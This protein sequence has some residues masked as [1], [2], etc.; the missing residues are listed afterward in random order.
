M[1]RN[2]F[3]NNAGVY[4]YGLLLVVTCVFIL[5]VLGYFERDGRFYVVGHLLS[6]LGGFY[7]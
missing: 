3:Y 1:G 2:L 5:N 4:G 7:V 6:C